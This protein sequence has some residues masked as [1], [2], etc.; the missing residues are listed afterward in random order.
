MKNIKNWETFNELKA[1]TYRSYANK[2][3]NK[4]GIN[5]SKGVEKHIGMIRS[6]KYKDLEEFKFEYN[7]TGTFVGFDWGMTWDNWQDN[8]FKTIIISP[9]FKME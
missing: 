1:D 5:K 9:S 6:L 2:L 8:D 3:K 7:F 4:Y